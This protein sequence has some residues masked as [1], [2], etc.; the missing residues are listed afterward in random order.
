MKVHTGK[1]LADRKL[2][3]AK[4]AARTAAIARKHQA[5]VTATSRFFEAVTARFDTVPLVGMYSWLDVNQWTSNAD[6]MV[7]LHINIT[8]IVMSMKEGFVPT[9]IKVLMEAGWD[10]TATSD[11]VYT[12]S[13]TREFR[14]FRPANEKHVATTVVFNAKP[15]DDEAA[16]C[17]KIQIGTELK[18]VPI[19]K[20][21]CPEADLDQIKT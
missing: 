11:Y 14:L 2:D 7:A 20:L 12:T 6:D 8:A 15:S 21:D 10:A 19:F 3:E 4:R 9:L 17:R 1:E 18:E 13:A 16:T 5:K